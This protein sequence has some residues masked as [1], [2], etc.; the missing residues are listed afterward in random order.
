MTLEE[1]GWVTA[2]VKS[3]G[4]PCPITIEASHLNAGLM[5]T[6]DLHSAPGGPLDFPICCQLA[7]QSGLQGL[8]HKGKLT[9][10]PI[11]HQRLQRV[12]K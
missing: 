1:L 7:D 2:E 11:D 4:V 12:S 9:G 10:H 5:R 6:R 8:V 3:G